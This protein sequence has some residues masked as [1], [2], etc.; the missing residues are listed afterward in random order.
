[1]ASKSSPCNGVVTPPSQQVDR[2]QAI[3]DERLE[4]G[5]KGTA[6]VIKPSDPS[7]LEAIQSND[8]DDSVS[9]NPRIWIW[10]LAGVLLLTAGWFAVS[11]PEIGSVHF[12]VDTPI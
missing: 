3:S 1:M 12:I 5:R 8:A 9:P 10:Q 4:T 7:P 2:F 11:V 6:P